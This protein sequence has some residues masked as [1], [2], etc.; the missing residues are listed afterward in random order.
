M[1]AIITIL[2]RG[3]RRIR[4][5][6]LVEIAPQMRR[7]KVDAGFGGMIEGGRVR[8]GIRGEADSD[9]TEF[10]VGEFERVW[11]VH[12][13]GWGGGVGFVWC[14]ERKFVLGR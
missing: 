5:I 11:D 7:A 9:E 2:S 8:V 1:R 14:L 3:I 4:I 13:L 10:D 6:L 12:S